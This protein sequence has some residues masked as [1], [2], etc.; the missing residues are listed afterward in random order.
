MPSDSIAGFLDRAQAV[1]VLFPEQVE[2]LIRQPD[3]PQTDLSKLCEYLLSRGVLTRYQAEAI[4]EAR[5]QEL[6]FA[7]YPIVDELGPCPGGI[8]YKALHPSLRTPIVLRRIRSDWLAPADNGPN[9]VARARA[10]GMSPHPNGVPLLDA[11]FYCDELYVVLDPPTGS[12]D[13]ESL[14]HEVGG[15]MPGFLAAEYGR[16]VASVLRMIHERG[17]VHGDVRPA[18]LLVGPLTVKSGSDGT[19]RRRP[20][21][22]AVVRLAEIGLVPTRLPAVEQMPEPAALP[23]LPPERVDSPLYDGRSD[24]YGLGATLYFLLTGRAPFAGE[25]SEQILERIR[26][27]E[28]ARLATL[29]PDLPPEFVALIRRMIDR[30]PERRPATAAEVEQALIPFCRP[31]TVPVQP[32]P[33]VV[34]IADVAMDEPVPVATPV[35][36]PSDG[37]GVD[38]A[39]FMAVHSSSE[40]QP[41][42]REL[43]TSDRARTRFLLLLGGVLHI[44]G[45]SLLLAWVFGAFNS[46]PEPDNSPPVEKK[47]DSIKKGKGKRPAPPS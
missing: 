6:N 29:R 43:T 10:I 30:Q 47:D 36:E 33:T 5:G 17:G 18:N 41:R 37:W 46:T 42:K 28:P 13:L 22:D 20:A 12:I 27:G 35:A 25:D 40:S 11:G 1:R 45:I 31:G 38:P 39:A 15:A 2:Q 34:P 7:G 32:S 9:Y 23:Y 26:T 3:T 24:I 21:P 19:E 14:A 16:A 44:A 8:A 4:R